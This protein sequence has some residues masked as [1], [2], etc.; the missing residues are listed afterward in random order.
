MIE[1][2]S[3]IKPNFPKLFPKLNWELLKNF[4]RINFG[5]KMVA[6]I[7]LFL[8]F[9]MIWETKARFAFLGLGVFGSFYF[10]NFFWQRFLADKFSWSWLWLRSFSLFLVLLFPIFIGIV[11]INLPSEVLEKMPTFLAKPSSTFWHRMRTNATLEIL[12]T[13]NNWQFGFGLGASGPAA[14]L[15]YYDIKQQKIF[16]N[17]EKVAY[18]YRLVGEDLTIP[19]NWFLQVLTN[20]GI[21]Y[22]GLYLVL[23]FWPI[24]PILKILQK[25]SNS[26]NLDLQTL[27]SLGFF[28]VI[29]GNLFLH[30]WESQT[31]ALMWT[32]IYLLGQLNLLN[33]KFSNVNF[34]NF[35]QNLN[36]NK[37]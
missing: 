17:Y 37:N 34:P 32:L 23:V 12:T 13:D 29:I 6:G 2:K 15:E 35:D 21:I 30:L 25:P 28:G 24:L 22:F 1:L 27:I 3:K 36:S 11:A 14:K 26:W 4:D 33:Q 9:W 7:C 10:L 5:K 18:K 8:V 19:E 16:K 20:G 31:V